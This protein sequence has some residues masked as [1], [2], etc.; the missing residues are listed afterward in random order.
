MNEQELYADNW[1]DLN[2]TEWL[3][4][5]PADGDLPTI[6]SDPG[7]SV[8]AIVT[9]MVSSTSAKQDEAHVDELAR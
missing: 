1:L 2:W 5:D 8:F 4:L 7:L 3:S 9:A 6:S